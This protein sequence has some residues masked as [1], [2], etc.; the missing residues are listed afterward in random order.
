[1]TRES[2]FTYVGSLNVVR[3]TIHCICFE[4]QAAL[5]WTKARQ[6]KIFGD[7]KLCFLLFQGNWSIRFYQLNK[8][9][10]EILQTNEY[11]GWNTKRRTFFPKITCKSLYIRFSIEKPYST[12]AS[13]FSKQSL[14]VFDCLSR[15]ISVI[16]Y[17]FNNFVTNRAL[18]FNITSTDRKPPKSWNKNL[19]FFP[20][21][22]STLS[23][24]GRY[25]LTQSYN[26]KLRKQFL[27]AKYN[28]E[29]S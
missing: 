18:K 22:Y 5:R 15:K 11:R 9:N 29:I 24:D 25:S 1:M 23:P 21:E 17:K 4:F 8:I 26:Y 2:I 14:L 27:K 28:S 20:I 10:S 12:I 16:I 13:L 3:K 7:L 19:F 6:K